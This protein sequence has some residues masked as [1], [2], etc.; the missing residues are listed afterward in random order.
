M[1]LIAAVSA[2]PEEFVGKVTQVI[3]GDSIVVEGIGRVR[4]ADIDAYQLPT[5]RGERARQFTSYHLLGRNVH[6]DLDDMGST[7]PAG[8][9]IALVYMQYPNN[10]TVKSVPFNRILVDYDHAVVHNRTD[11]EFDPA[12]WWL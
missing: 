10:S 7:C 4:M 11:N 2:S 3:D 1:I 6:L 8:C 5:D 12:R 9:K